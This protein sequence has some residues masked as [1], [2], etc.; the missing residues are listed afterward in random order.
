MENLI[1]SESQQKVSN[2]GNLH[3]PAV[4]LVFT[5]TVSLYFVYY[6]LN[7]LL[8]V[9]TFS[10]YIHFRPSYRLVSGHF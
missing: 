2:N 5:I 1:E 7:M 9:H 10:F 3:I 8:D 4:V 6:D